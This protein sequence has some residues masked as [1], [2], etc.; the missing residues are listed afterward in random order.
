MFEDVLLVI[1]GCIRGEE[2]AWNIFV[3]EFGSMA[4]NILRKFSDLASQDRKDIIQNVFVRLLKGGL[5]NFH[6]LTK[7]EF[8]KYFKRIVINEAISHLKSGGRDKKGVSLNGEVKVNG[9]EG[10]EGSSLYDLFLI[11]N[12]DSHSGPE[13]V[14]EE[15][16]VLD[17]IKKVME[18]FPLLDQQIFWMKLQGYKDEEVRKILG[19]PLGT[20]ASKYF[21]IR[22]KII[23]VLGEK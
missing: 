12:Q 23:A 18:G 6:G 22:T 7:Y 16:E 1:E 20:V 14:A 4:N 5:G 19:I 17:M 2:R 11:P 10:S 13:S 8:F 15:K 3:K 21:R 9:E